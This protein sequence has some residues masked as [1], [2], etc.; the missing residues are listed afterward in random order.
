VF[1]VPSAL[2]LLVGIENFSRYFVL[3]FKLFIQKQSR[4]SG[5]GGGGGGSSL[6]Q[7]L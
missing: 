7:L 4:E 6:A 2:C 5:G 1:V 3:C